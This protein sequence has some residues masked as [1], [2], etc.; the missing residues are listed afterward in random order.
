V[1]N[2][3][4][5]L[6]EEKKIKEIIATDKIS[7]YQK[8]TD[9][10]YNIPITKEQEELFRFLFNA[11]IQ[12][13]KKQNKMP[14][15]TELAKDSVDIINKLNLKLPT[16]W[17]V[18]GQIPLMIPDPTKEFITCYMPKNAQE[19]KKAIQHLLALNR[20]MKV[21]ER[22]R[23][24]Y[25]RYDN[26]LYQLKEQLINE[27]SY[28][29][30]EQ[31]VIDD[32]TEFYVKCPISDFPEIFDLT[33]KLYSLVNKLKILGCLKK[34]K[35]EIVLSLDSLWKFIAAYQLLDSISKNPQYNKNEILQFNLGPAIETKKYCA[36]EAISNLESIYLSELPNKEF[37]IS[38]EA[39]EVREIMSGWDGE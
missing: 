22:E 5:E 35:L 2:Y 28:M 16:A 21:R 7:Y 8:I 14:R 13:Y 26:R 33:E 4:L 23:N 34:Y 15:K 29:E 11:I 38:E 27:A 37:D 24:H 18:Y 30:N 19:I 25:V 31:K 17:Y 1:Q 12:E 20:G 39:K 3:V 10:Y 9:T 6:L 36:Q 32:F